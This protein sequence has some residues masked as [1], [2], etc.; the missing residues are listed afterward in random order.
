MSTPEQAT[1]ATVAQMWRAVLEGTV[2]RSDAHAWAA[3]WVD[4]DD[5]DVRD[6]MVWSALQRLHGFDLVWTSPAQ[7][8]VRHGGPGVDVHPLRDIR[9]ALATWRAACEEY[10]ADPEGYVRRMRERARAAGME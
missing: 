6:P 7:T 2:S 3:Q 1:R 9:S 4:A 10:D 8:T 5:P